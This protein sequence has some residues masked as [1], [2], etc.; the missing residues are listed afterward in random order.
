MSISIVNTRFTVVFAL[1]TVVFVGVAMTWRPC[2]LVMAWPASTCA[3]LAA[4]YAG[5]VPNACGKHANGQLRLVNVVFLLPYLCPYWIIWRLRRV[6]DRQECCH[7]ISPGL[8]V[9]RRLMGHELP[10]DIGLVVDLTSEF[11]EPE[12]LRSTAHYLCLPILDGGAVPLGGLLNAVSKINAFNGPTLIHCAEGHGRSAMLAIA[13]LIARG[14]AAEIA[15]A[16]SMI[17]SHRPNARLRRQQRLLLELAFLELNG[18]ATAPAT[19][20]SSVQ[21]EG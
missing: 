16:L 1:V 17:R 14:T 4:G 18:R 21:S 11:A 15:E 7:E 6:L 8:F 10:H 13:V 12:Q 2:A 5:L 9:G 3:L 20:T 19:G